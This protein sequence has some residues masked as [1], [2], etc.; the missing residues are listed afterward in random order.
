MCVRQY[1]TPA[2]IAGT[3]LIDEKTAFKEA[4]AEFEQ[5]CRS[6]PHGDSGKRK[7]YC[8]SWL[9]KLDSATHL[10]NLPPDKHAG[11]LIAS[12]YV[13]V[14]LARSV[15]FQ[16]DVTVLCA[17]LDTALSEA[18]QSGNEAA[19]FYVLFFAGTIL[20]RHG[21]D[22]GI[23]WIQRALFF[24]GSD[25]ASWMRN[26]LSTLGQI[27][28]EDAATYQSAVL[29]FDWVCLTDRAPFLE[30]CLKYETILK[31]GD[32]RI[33]KEQAA[34]A[35]GESCYECGATLAARL[36]LRQTRAAYKIAEIG[37]EIAERTSDGSWSTIFRQVLDRRGRSKRSQAPP[38]R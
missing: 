14:E 17:M 16:I 27:W 25:G 19:I 7:A 28:G 11:A 29:M 12:A 13:R 23:A 21:V 20:E 1:D 10:T 24:A 31:H 38:E 5:G 34:R 15:Q 33:V 4:T 26:V 37:L 35:P 30:L 8:R 2:S 6:I 3:Q 36:A 18:E 32:V 9:E 22:Y